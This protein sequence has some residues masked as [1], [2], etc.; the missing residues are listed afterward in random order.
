M[1]RSKFYT[2][3]EKAVKQVDVKDID[4]K[5]N[6]LEF[7][8]EFNKTLAL[9]KDCDEQ[10]KKEQLS[11]PT[12]EIF[13]T[14]KELKTK[15]IYTY[16]ITFKKTGVTFRYTDSEMCYLHGSHLLKDFVV[17][18]SKEVTTKEGWCINASQYGL[19]EVRVEV[20]IDNKEEYEHVREEVF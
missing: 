2:I 15:A 9:L 4:S 14:E 1:T 18:D 10:Y 6:Q 12:L 16:K 8:N 11:L 20:E 17:V 19:P 7:Y 3:L 13:I 5:I